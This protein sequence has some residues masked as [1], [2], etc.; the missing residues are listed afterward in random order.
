[1]EPGETENIKKNFQT[2]FNIFREA[3]NI[4]HLQNKNKMLQKQKK[5][6]KKKLENK[7]IALGK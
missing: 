5:K 4:L 2:N 7:N 1:M 6:T 3:R